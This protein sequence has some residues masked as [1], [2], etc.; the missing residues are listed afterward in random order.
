VGTA[1]IGL[2]RL[3]LAP[4]DLLALPESDG[5][6]AEL[7]DRLRRAVAAPAGATVV[8]VAVRDPAWAPSV[9]ALGEWLGLSQAVS[10]LV[11]A[12]R[13]VEPRDLIAPGDGAAPGAIDTAEL[14]KR[15]DAAETRLRSAF[16]A[17]QGG[18]NLEAALL[19]V[20]GFGAT[21]AV[22]SADPSQ[23]SAQAAAVAAEIGGRIETLTRLA[24]GL[25]RSTAS[26]E[27]SRD[28]DVARLKAVFG[29]S[30]LVLPVLAPDL[31]ATWPALWNHSVSL[32]G[33]DPLASVRWLQRMSRVRPGAARLDQA[34]LYAEALAGRPLTRFDVAQLPAADGERWLGLDLAGGAPASR[35]SLVA[36]SPHPYT[37]GA[38]VAGLM[39]D[40]WIEV[41]PT[42]QQITGVSFHHD[43]P[44][45]QA[46]QAILLAVRPDDFPEW[47]LEAVEGSVLE[48]LGLAK[49]RA[50]DPD[51]LGALGHY[52]PA[53]YFAYNA[54]GPRPDAIS[55]DFNAALRAASQR[56]S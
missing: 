15:A 44:A 12:A 30:F 31:A 28:H 8:P 14:Q 25:S 16:A 20:A 40:E 27:A 3:G 10:R 21:G 48:A 49:L 18:G 19:A 37:A 5:L 51:A 54:G 26:P 42:A 33:G 46:P 1:E 45:A 56:I 4:L 55:T 34:L 11:G 7:A 41:L 6:P 24:S 29:D 47:T 35:L 13:A 9:V 36:F 32:Q 22:P 38:A 50:V 17:L 2:D 52:L 39:I 53:L 43:D 23:W